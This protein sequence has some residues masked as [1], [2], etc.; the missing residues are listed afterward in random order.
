M[1]AEVFPVIGGNGRPIAVCMHEH[2]ADRGVVRPP[3]GVDL[4]HIVT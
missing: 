1:P 4:D 2:N 3:E